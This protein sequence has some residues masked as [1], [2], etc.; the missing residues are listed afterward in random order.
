MLVYYPFAQF[1][2]G[3]T[4][5]TLGLQNFTEILENKQVYT[6]EVVDINFNVDIMWMLIQM[7]HISQVHIQHTKINFKKT[8][9]LS[10]KNVYQCNWPQNPYEGK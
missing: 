2:V 6:D 7:S 4:F 1:Q 5:V 3:Y 9:F 8:K 10:Q